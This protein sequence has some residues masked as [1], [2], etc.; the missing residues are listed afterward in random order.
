[1]MASS[2]DLETPIARIAQMARAVG[3]H[4]ILAT[5][6]PS[7]EVITGLSKQTSRPGLPLKWPA[8]STPRSS[9]MMSE[10]RACLAT[11]ICSSYRREPPRSSAHKAHTSAMKRSTKSSPSSATRPLPNYLI[12]SFDTMRI[13]DASS[14]ET[15]ED[16]PR[17]TLYDQAY[18]SRR[19]P[20]R[21]HNLLAA[22]T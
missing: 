6:R 2:S 22:Q 19:D 11:A 10:Q 15:V 9:S 5:Q 8:V 18:S 13:E 17:D 14:T 16:N 1:M 3:I 12:Q 20:Y 7:R 4:L 21:F